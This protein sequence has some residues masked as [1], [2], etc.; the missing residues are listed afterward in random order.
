[1]IR[2]A[3][4]VQAL[5]LTLLLASASVGAS[6]GGAAPIALTA[7]PS[8]VDLAG[9]GR[10]TVRLT[11]SGATHV[12]VDVT[13]AGFALD[14]RGRPRI[15]TPSGVGRSAAHWLSFRPHV[16]SLAPRASTAVTVTSRLPA[17]V[18]PGDH[19]ALLL[20]T[21]RRRLEGSVAARMRLGVVVVVRA[22]G[23]VTHR[24]RLRGLRATRRGGVRTLEL[25]VSNRGNVTESFA[26]SRAMLSLERGA[27]R[28]AR[29]VAEPR[30]LRPF[31]NGVFRF[32]YPRT[33]AGHAIARV[34]LEPDSGH[35]VRR[36]FQ[37][38][39]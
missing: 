26:R 5:A 17:H 24:L 32:R 37:V 34:Q 25:L 29:L 27:R 22:P 39:L 6:S 21:S 30:E 3:V 10:A 28:I 20:L 36:A 23:A 31:T 18:E 11:N 13:R 33:L 2:S 1:M 12:V 38:R 19:D 15:V 14:L 16:V 8:H 7:S 4:C 35:L 9:A